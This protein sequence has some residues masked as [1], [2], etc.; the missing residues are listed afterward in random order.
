MILEED[1]FVMMVGEQ[2]RTLLVVGDDESICGMLT[3][4]NYSYEK[5]SSSLLRTLRLF[6][7]P[8]LY[9]FI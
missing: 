5:R 1:S 9:A 2:R 6:I 8:D 3:H 7:L 4:Q